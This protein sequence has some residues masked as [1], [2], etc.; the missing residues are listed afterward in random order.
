MSKESLV[1]CHRICELLEIE[2]TWARLHTDGMLRKVGL[3]PN[4]IVETIDTP[5]DLGERF[6]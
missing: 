4:V 3:L 5:L 6:V 2:R 1:R